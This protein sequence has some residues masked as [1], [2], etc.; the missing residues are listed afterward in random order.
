MPQLTNLS[1][2]LSIPESQCSMYFSYIVAIKQSVILLRDG[3]EIRTLNRKQCDTSFKMINEQNK[4]SNHI[5]T[6]IKSAISIPLYIS[7]LATQ[8]TNAM[9]Y[10]STG[11]DE[12]QE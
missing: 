5:N 3:V 8:Y 10:F 6:E 11:E 1:I 9:C 12:K 2:N 7:V 4:F